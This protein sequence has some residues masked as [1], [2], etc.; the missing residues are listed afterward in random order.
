MQGIMLTSH[1]H[2][3][4]ERSEIQINGGERDGEVVYTSST[5]HHPVTKTFDTPLEIKAGQGL[6][7][8]VTYNNTTNR[9]V[10]FGLTSEDEMAIIYG[11]YY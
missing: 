6:R 2:K 9:T 11:Y 5:W 4:P 10:N 7:M 1:T 8:I 3:L